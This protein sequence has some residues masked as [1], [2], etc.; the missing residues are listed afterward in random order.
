VTGESSGLV[1][2]RQFATD[3]WCPEVATTARGFAY[4]AFYD[5]WG[6]ACSVQQSSVMPYLWV[7][8]DGHRMHLTPDQARG[9][10]GELLAYADSAE[11]DGS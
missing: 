6:R 7:G 1:A 10:A 5:S 3:T 2:L 4:T 8:I 11:G 9:L